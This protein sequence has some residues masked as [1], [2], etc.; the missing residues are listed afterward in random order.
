MRGAVV[1]PVAC[2]RMHNLLVEIASGQLHNQTVIIGRRF[3]YRGR[4][5]IEFR[6]V[7]QGAVAA[8]TRHPGHVA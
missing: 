7:R 8:A 5:R 2:E 3:R 1:R 6:A 4:G